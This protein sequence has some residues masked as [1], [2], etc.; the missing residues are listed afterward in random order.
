[1]KAKLRYIILRKKLLREVFFFLKNKKVNLQTIDKKILYFDDDSYS[2]KLI[3]S[4]LVVSLTSYGDRINELKYTLFSL[5]S[6]T[7][8]PELIVVYLAKKDI[9]LLNS[10]LMWFENKGVEF[11][12]TEDLKSYKKL[13]PA[14]TDF[15]NK[16]IVTA[17]DD[18]FYSKTWLQKIW[19]EHLIYPDYILGNLMKKITFSNNGI[20]NPYSKWLYNYRSTEISRFNFLLGG[21]GTLYPPNSLYKDVLNTGLIFN[22]CPSADDI[23]F[24]FMSFLNHTKIKQINQPETKLCYVNPYREYGIVEGAT[25]TQKNVLNGQ[26]DIQFRQIMNHYHITDKKLYS[27]Q[28]EEWK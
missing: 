20:L 6:Q 5:I 18:L 15:P 8:R 12:P 24:Y 11:R 4:N 17:D 13:I 26:N 22:L 7:I 16:C 23:W 27:L 1:M 2:S 3:T 9:S 19:S 28:I 14:L 21:S 25:L 10:D